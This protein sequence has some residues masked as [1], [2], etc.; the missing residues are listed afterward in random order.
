M[1]NLNVDT[2]GWWE[3]LNGTYGLGRHTAVY[4]GHLLS[5][6]GGMVDG[7]HSQVS[8]MIKEGIGVNV[9]VIGN[10]CA[11]LRDLIGYHLYEH[12][13][14]LDPT[15]WSERWLPIVAARKSAWNNAFQCAAKSRIQGT[16]PSHALPDYIGDYSNPTYGVVTITLEG[17]YLQ[18]RARHLVF[19]LQ[20]YHY[21]RF[22]T[23]DSDDE[24]WCITFSTTERGHVDQFTTS[25]AECALTFY[26]QSPMLDFDAMH[27][28]TGKYQN[29]SGVVL[30][31]AVG[32]DDCL[33][34]AQPGYRNTKL[35]PYRMNQFTS[36]SI[37][38]SVFEFIDQDNVILSLEQI[39]N[40]QR[41][42][43][44]KI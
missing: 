7:F 15:P 20:H 25:Y 31:V 11:A 32:E 5:Y 40:F 4:R 37:P 12:L 22:D 43:F 18:L 42:V 21:D 29:E 2:Y 34:L 44:W 17:N 8:T 10:H 33:W 41:L 24:I 26:R 30:T 23:P 3:L 27:R 36:A 19:P 28:L 9:F 13:L 16:A 38:N 35:S 14:G 39:T 6:H 1:P